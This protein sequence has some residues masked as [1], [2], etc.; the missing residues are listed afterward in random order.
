MK[1]IYAAMI[2]ALGLVISGAAMAD[3]AAAPAGGDAPKAEKPMKKGKKGGKKHGKKKA[4]E[5]KDAPAPEAK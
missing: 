4:E 2:A 3:D 5:K 1:G